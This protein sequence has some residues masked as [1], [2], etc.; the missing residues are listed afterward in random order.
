MKIELKGRELSL[1]RWEVSEAIDHGHF[2]KSSGYSADDVKKDVESIDDYLV[3]IL[4]V[5]FKDGVVICE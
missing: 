3:S 5:L 2:M 1:I 4:S